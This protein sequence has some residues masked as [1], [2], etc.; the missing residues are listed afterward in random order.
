[1]ARVHVA[2]LRGG[3]SRE[4]DVSLATGAAVIE[5]LPE[6]RYHV[7]DVLIS[8]DG[9]WHTRGIPTTP[10]R[11]LR[12]VDVAFVGLHGAYG[13]DGQVQRVLEAHHIPYTGSGVLASAMAMNKA[14]TREHV[15]ACEGVTM[16]PYTVLSAQDVGEDYTGAAQHVFAQFGPAYIVKPLRGGSSLGVVIAET[17]VSL[18]DTLAL[19]FE[20]TDAVI[21]ERYIQGREATCGVLEH[22]RGEQVYGLPPIEIIP[23]EKSAFWDYDAKYDG[24]TTEICPGNFSEDEKRRMQDAARAVHRALGLR[25]YSRSDFIVAPSGIYFL[26]V[27]TLP[28]LTPHS[29]LPKAVDAVGV[30]F[31]DFLEHLIALARQR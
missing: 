14:Q 12:D 27:N 3:P 31:G 16:P 21:V 22:F 6:E 11:A 2:V 25:H 17:V 30:R 9:T 19:A 24:S 4:Y 1:M 7:K 18:A 29:L 8:R 10:E 28:G 13:E 20:D 23:P 15:G 5:H 26:E